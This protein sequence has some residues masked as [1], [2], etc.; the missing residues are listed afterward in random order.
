MI[1]LSHLEATPGASLVIGSLINLKGL[2][3]GLSSLNIFF[4][5]GIGLNLADHL[6][7]TAI[8]LIQFVFLE[9]LELVLVKILGDVHLLQLLH[10]LVEELGL[11]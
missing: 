2:E 3:R 9:L 1:L 4:L 5:V 8:L 11:D 6:A 7:G 10:L